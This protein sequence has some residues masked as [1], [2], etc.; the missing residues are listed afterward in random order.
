MFQSAPRLVAAE[1][2]SSRGQYG[3]KMVSIRSAACGRGERGRS[4]SRINDHRVSIRSAACGRGEP[5]RA[6]TAATSIT[7]S[8]RSAAC[9]RGEPTAEKNLFTFTGFQSAPRLVAAENKLARDKHGN[10]ISFNPLRGLWPRRT[11][12][13]RNAG[14][15][16]W[17]SI[18]S[19]ACGRGEPR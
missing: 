2:S 14:W 12:R 19:A 10:E 3:R 4:I 9:G 6:K 1:N 18:R 15:N 13:H 11:C 17:V 8:I 16:H 5:S 7:V